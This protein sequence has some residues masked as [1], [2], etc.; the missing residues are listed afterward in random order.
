MTLTDDAC[1]TEQP[2]TRLAQRPVFFTQRR[3]ERLELPHHLRLAQHRRSQA[4]DD[5]EQQPIR[6]AFDDGLAGRGRFALIIK[7]EY[8]PEAGPPDRD[9]RR[10][11][12][13]TRRL[14]VYDDETHRG[15]VRNRGDR[16]V[17]VLSGT[18]T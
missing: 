15:I 9:V 6:V 18:G 1:F 7:E 17:M 11:G 12:G 4:A 5:L 2:L 8:F 14:T 16:I 13:L 10:H 3:E